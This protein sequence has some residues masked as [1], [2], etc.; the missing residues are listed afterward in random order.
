MEHAVIVKKFID[1][2]LLTVPASNNV[3]RILPPLISS[4]ENILEALDIIQQ[5]LHEI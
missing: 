1:N 5:S 2:K 3:I 4:K